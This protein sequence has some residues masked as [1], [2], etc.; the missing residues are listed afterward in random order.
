MLDIS[1]CFVLERKM[2]LGHRVTPQTP[3]R[4]GGLADATEARVGAV[5]AG[6]V[7][8]CALGTGAD[9][10]PQAS[11]KEALTGAA[12]RSHLMSH[13]LSRG[14]GIQPGARHRVDAHSVPVASGTLGSP[15][16]RQPKVSLTSLV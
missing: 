13:T 16:E 7:L 6:P 4:A 5:E 2:L 9:T 15:V 12:P 14:C 11:C 10:V 3:A 1:P 8:P